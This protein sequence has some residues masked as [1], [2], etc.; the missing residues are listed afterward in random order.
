ML[1][2]LLAARSSEVSGLRVDNVRFEKN[3]VV[4]ARQIYPG[5]GGPITKQTKSRKERLVRILDPLRP[6]LD[7]LTAGK[8]PEDQLL[9]GPQGGV[10]TTATVRDATNW[11]KIVAGIGL[12]DLTRHCLRHTGATWMPGAGIPLRVLQ[13]IL[14]QAWMETTRGYLHADDRHLASA[15]KQGSAFLSLSGQRRRARQK[16]PPA[17]GRTPVTQPP[18]A[19]RLCCGSLIHGKGHATRPTVHSQANR[20][21]FGG[22]VGTNGNLTQDTTK[23]R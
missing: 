21:T 4:I 22:P 13:E 8:D 2:A 7:S 17:R 14:G 20:K 23:P 6:V 15:A 1:A 16:P 12:P 9:V 11:D 18:T 5:R 3:L 10:L 19:C